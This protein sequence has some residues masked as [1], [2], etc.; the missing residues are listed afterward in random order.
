MAKKKKKAPPVKKQKTDLFRGNILEPSGYILVFCIVV[1][2]FVFCVCILGSVGGFQKI[3]LSVW[4]LI[5][6]PFLFVLGIFAGVLY[7]GR[8]AHELP[9]WLVEIFFKK[10]SLLCE[11]LSHAQWKELRAQRKKKKGK[12][13]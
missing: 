7:V 10:S 11:P 8:H 6:T 2:F 1:A 5:L 3:P 4:L 13:G 12:S 9:R